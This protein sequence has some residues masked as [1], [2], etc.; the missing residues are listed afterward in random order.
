MGR[1][2]TP[3]YADGLS[4]KVRGSRGRS[5]ISSTATV[6]PIS[7]AVRYAMLVPLALGAGFAALL[8]GLVPG[9]SAAVFAWTMESPTA[10]LLGAGYAGSC[11]MLWLAAARATRW[12]HVRVTVFS[13]SLFMLLMPAALVLGR[14]TLHLR[15]GGLVGVLSAWGWLAVHLVAPLVGA[16]ALGFQVFAAG[17]RPDRP[18]PLPWW[19]A[20]PMLASGAVLGGLGI[21][22]FAVPAPAAHRWPW[23]VSQLDVRVIGAWSLAFGAATLLSIRERDLRRV[24]HGMAALVVT[25][26]LGL[27]GLVRCAGQVHWGSLGTWVIVAVLLNL[28]GMGLCGLGLSAL[29]PVPVPVP[30]P[31]NQA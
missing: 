5:V 11:A 23:E 14:G 27:V 22:L 16:V 31:V 7:P 4:N 12:S 1:R 24:R 8:L 18:E 25:G 2:P 9:S 15:S 17:V 30:A 21:A 20:A 26:L 29:L 13:S 10:T 6:D 3:P 19:V 28:L